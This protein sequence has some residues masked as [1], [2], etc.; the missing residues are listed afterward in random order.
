MGG[1]GGGERGV[2][3]VAFRLR[4]PQPVFPQYPAVNTS[5]EC[6]V[7]V[8]V[9]VSGVFCVYLHIILYVGLCSYLYVYP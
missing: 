6:E 7:G 8:V 3:V 2:G 5:A 1:G 4:G 9:L